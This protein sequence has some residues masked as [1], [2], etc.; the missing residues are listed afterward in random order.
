MIWTKIKRHST[1]RTTQ[2]SFRLLLLRFVVFMPDSDFISI[3]LGLLEVISRGHPL[4]YSSWLIYQS[5]WQGII[6]YTY[7]YIHMCQMLVSLCV[8]L[9]PFFSHLRDGKLRY[10]DQSH[11][12]FVFMCLAL[13]FWRSTI[14]LYCLSKFGT[15]WMNT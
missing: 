8:L 9:I 7:I 4:F 11:S 13:K 1:N 10:S 5:I 6:Y 12:E 15:K 2:A 14:M 3:D